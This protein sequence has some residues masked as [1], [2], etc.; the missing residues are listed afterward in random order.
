MME[1]NISYPVG[2]EIH[3]SAAFLLL[4]HFKN[5]GSTIA[6]I[7]VCSLVS[8]KSS[9]LLITAGTRWWDIII[10]EQVE[11]KISYKIMC[12][13]KTVTEV[14]LFFVTAKEEGYAQW[15]TNVVLEQT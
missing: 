11:D 4:A 1:G 6:I 2:K 13:V 14:R 5:W 10:S 8:S 3:L 12:C 9:L 15:L 7:Q